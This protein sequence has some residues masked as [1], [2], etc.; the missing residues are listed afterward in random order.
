[1]TKNKPLRSIDQRVKSTTPPPTAR[2]VKFNPY[3][4]GIIKGEEQSRYRVF[5]DS[6]EDWVLKQFDLRRSPGNST[7]IPVSIRVPTLVIR[8]FN[9]NFAVDKLR[10]Y[11]A[12]S[13]DAFDEDNSTNDS[14][15][16]TGEPAPNLRIVSFTTN[17][18][19]SIN[20][21]NASREISNFV[22]N[23]I[24]RHTFFDMLQLMYSDMTLADFN[25]IT[26]V[27]V[28]QSLFNSGLGN[29]RV[30]AQVA[31]IPLN[32]V[33]DINNTPFILRSPVSSSYRLTPDQLRGADMSKT[34]LAIT[35]TQL[36]FSFNQVALNLVQYTVQNETN[37]PFIRN[38]TYVI[39]SVNGVKPK[40]VS[41]SVDIARFLDVPKKFNSSKV[42]I[43]ATA[44]N[45]LL[46]S[47][48]SFKFIL[49]SVTTQ[50]NQV[51]TGAQITTNFNVARQYSISYGSDASF[52]ESFTVQTP[53][54]N[55]IQG[56]RIYRLLV[57][58]SSN[59]TGALFVYKLPNNTFVPRYYPLG[60]PTQD[61][62]DNRLYVIND[63][64]KLTGSVA[65]S[66]KV[67][68]N[69][70]VSVDIYPV[71]TFGK[72]S[73]VKST[74]VNLSGLVNLSRDLQ[75]NPLG[76]YRQSITINSR[77]EL[78]FSQGSRID[79][80]LLLEIPF[81]VVVEIKQ[82]GLFKQV[83]VTPVVYHARVMYR[84]LGKVIR[85]ETQTGAPLTLL[86]LSPV[87]GS[88]GYRVRLVPETSAL[89]AYAGTY[90]QV[91]GVDHIGILQGV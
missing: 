5:L 24:R 1:M 20:S 42:P 30:F 7:T 16:D 72:C 62:G 64:M 58:K 22:E 21:N 17:S 67:A 46:S 61:I 6:D 75:N 48:F 76:Y 63:Y 73:L 51:S 44:R 4:G 10:V 80:A 78:V 23:L 40:A 52:T 29:L 39:P 55:L 36:V 41:I 12:F 84:G 35:G 14:S 54:L 66:Y 3:T 49:T 68:I 9:P 50:A 37:T 60:S 26:D 57:N 85:F 71:N 13:K 32:P 15:T 34:S 19:T 87:L 8:I 11:L 65:D 83:Y 89:S 45:N 74:F 90:S 33:N 43:S 18:I 91:S 47:S 28:L 88:A 38:A 82:N 56:Y 25:A 79:S 77:R 53:V 86:N 70:A 2:P 31:F 59:I 81:R 27:R 69:N